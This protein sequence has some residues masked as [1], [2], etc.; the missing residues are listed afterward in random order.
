MATTTEREVLR[1]RADLAGSG[2]SGEAELVEVGHGTQR[3][4]RVILRV[5]G[6]PSV[7]TPGL[8]GVHIHEKGSCE[9]ADPPF[10]SAM[11]HF[12]PGPA[13]NT[14]PDVNHP[15]HMGDLPNIEIGA[16]GSGV[17]EAVSTRITLSPGPLCIL[18]GDGTALMLH[19]QPDQG[20]SGPP[21]SGV[22]GGPR[23]ACGVIRRVP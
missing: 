15:F 13:S 12:D 21:K 17:L 18:D 7:L 9:H 1:A 14:D 2:I 8:H 6:D 23:L 10:M 16:D 5:R 11:G 4:V 20:I 3:L 22:S 19:G